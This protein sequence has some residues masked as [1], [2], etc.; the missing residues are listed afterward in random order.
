MWPHYFATSCFS[1]S[2]PSFA[3]TAASRFSLLAEQTFNLSLYLLLSAHR[4]KLDGALFLLTIW[5]RFARLSVVVV[6]VG[7][8]Q[9]EGASGAAPKAFSYSC[10]FVLSAS[11]FSLA[12]TQHESNF[13]E[14]NIFVR[15]LEC[16]IRFVSFW[17]RLRSS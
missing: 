11:F 8:G 12:Q 16:S 7:V 14:R 15:S 17:F 10:V 9:A 6:V 13:V 4:F 5:R 2:S 3:T 1:S